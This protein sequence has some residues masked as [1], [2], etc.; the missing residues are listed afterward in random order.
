MTFSYIKPD[1]LLLVLRTSFYRET[2]LKKDSLLKKTLLGK[3][4]ISNCLM[5]VLIYQLIPN[6]RSLITQNYIKL[7]IILYTFIKDTQDCTYQLAWSYIHLRY[8]KD[9]LTN[10]KIFNKKTFYFP[11]TTV[12]AIAFLCMY[13]NLF[14]RLFKQKD[15]QSIIL[16]RKKFPQW[17]VVKQRIRKIIATKNK[18]QDFNVGF[19]MI[20]HF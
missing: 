1:I 2:F 19:A 12:F 7:D 13:R 3:I 14:G 16:V 9:K 6:H 20:L 8:V 5:S 15:K 17:V 18:G 11:L 10:F 4:C